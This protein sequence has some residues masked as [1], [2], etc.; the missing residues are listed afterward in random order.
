MDAAEDR[1]AGGMLLL[2]HPPPLSCPPCAG[3]LPDGPVSD[4]ILAPWSPPLPSSG[5]GGSE[6]Q[7]TAWGVCTTMVRMALV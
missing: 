4:V 7:E 6:G 5:T 1:Y 3:R 2:W